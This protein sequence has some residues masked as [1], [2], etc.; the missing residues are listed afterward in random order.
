MEIFKN[1]WGESSDPDGIIISATIVEDG[2]L[3]IDGTD[4]G[5][6]ARGF[7]GGDDYEYGL[8]IPAEYLPAFTLELLKRSF[9]LRGQ[10]SFSKIVRICKNARIPVK[11]WY[12]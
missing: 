3:R 6:S 10:L 11:D 4:Y 2:S 1:E 5:S 9:N 7:S 12:F 8:L